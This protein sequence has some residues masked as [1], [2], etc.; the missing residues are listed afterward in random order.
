MSTHHERAEHWLDQ[1][2]QVDRAVAGPAKTLI[3][4]VATSTRG[5][6]DGGREPL[7]PTLLA[8][9]E[10]SGSS[11]LVHAVA[12]L[13]V[14]R[15]WHERRR[16]KWIDE[17]V[18]K[19]LREAAEQIPRVFTD[20]PSLRNGNP[21]DHIKALDDVAFGALNPLTASEIFRLLI[22]A[23]EEHA[24]G[25]LG[26]LALFSLAWALNRRQYGRF[27][28][29]ASLGLWRPTA[30]VTGRALLPI[31]RL[32]EI[33]HDRARY[34]RELAKLWEE[35]KNH[36]NGATQRNRWMFASTLDSLSAALRGL[37]ALSIK[38]Q[39]F[40]E[41]A[42]VLAGRADAIG[43]RTSIPPIA[44][45]M[46]A[47]LRRLFIRMGA[48]NEKVLAKARA[49]TDG[50]Q[51]DI[52]KLLWEPGKRGELANQCRLRVSGD[53]WREQQKAAEDAHELTRKALGILEEGVRLCANVPDDLGNDD[54]IRLFGQLANVNDRVRELL[55]DSVS[56]NVEWL[57]QVMTN[58]VAYAS[59]RKDSEFDVAE[60]LASV[61]LLQ[62]WNERILISRAEVEDAV[63]HALTTV[64]RDGSWAAGQPIYLEKRVVGVWPNTSDVMLLLT[65][66]ILRQS[67]ITA[68]DGQLGSFVL[69]LEGRAMK[70]P[71]PVKEG[72]KQAPLWEGWQ[73]ETR[74]D[75]ID[76]WSTST[77][78]RALLDTREIIEH[79]L[80]QICEERFM[81]VRDLNSLAKVDPV[82]LGA[83]HQ[84]RLHTQLMRMAAGARH[85][86]E[87]KAD[88]S[89][90]LHGPP[91]SSKTAI[92]EALGHEVTPGEGRFIR[93]TPADFTRQGQESLDAEASFIF[94]LLSRIRNA[95]IFFD[96][97]DDLL[98]FREIGDPPSFIKLVVPGMLNRLQDLRDFAPRQQL[99]FLLGTN[100]VDQIEPALTRRGR[101]DRLIP[102][103]YPDP[104]SRENIAERIHPRMPADVKEAVVASTAEWPWST[105][106]SL[107]KKLEKQPEA[108]VS[109][110]MD[111]IKQFSADFPRSEAYYADPMRWRRPGPLENEIVH[112][113][114]SVAKE[115]TACRERLKKLLQ[116]VSDQ[117]TVNAV[118]QKFDSEWRGE[119]RDGRP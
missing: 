96:E 11:L 9:E 40:E 65:S 80:W 116:K 109:E 62:R 81:I 38:P 14:Q 31:I 18:E 21:V 53:G 107:C 89:F 19:D 16:Y 44:A 26:F 10:S 47:V 54:I 7:V 61:A 50:I 95:T 114:F 49:S 8:R 101:I 117:E 91:G 103:A 83:R 68:A 64:R 35:I 45:E 27:M 87:R 17:G 86:D 100:Y 48:E 84:L 82:D 112:E 1:L 71:C 69:W 78:I 102:V 97:I 20:H 63:S 108:S 58:E 32:T 23:G 104:W 72:E 24:H 56:E 42:K 76:V 94:K 46:R 30:A 88:Y 113:S 51:K 52:V 115:P 4:L 73:S 105:Y 70:V 5:G 111:L 36:E 119:H 59:A 43:T 118:L 13:T 110:A 2:K 29:G 74:E 12:S 55:A 57:R 67:A 99:C 15:L 60:L 77:A 93:I 85:D 34:Y 6:W 39:D 106:Q 41:C 25:D 3:R 33:I 98:R 90:L 28:A 92:A 75:G 79:R 66:T 22:R 37:G